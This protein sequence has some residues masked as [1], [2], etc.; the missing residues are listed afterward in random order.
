MATTNNDFFRQEEYDNCDL[1]WD[2]E[3][4]RVMKQSN[5]WTTRKLIDW[6]IDWLTDKQIEMQTDRW[7][8]GTVV[9]IPKYKKYWLQLILNLICW[10]WAWFIV[11]TFF[12]L[13]PN[14]WSYMSPR[15][16]VFTLY[17]TNRTYAGG[18]NYRCIIDRWCAQ[19][20]DFT[21]VY[22]GKGLQEHICTWPVL[23]VR[24]WI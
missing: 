2:K 6:F 16:Q 12:G 22:E 23:P 9:A 13:L 4:E 7:M 8:D 21:K 3:V 10:G 15:W 17:Y 5:Q 14:L 1:K 20:C 24:W 18:S 19:E 11:P